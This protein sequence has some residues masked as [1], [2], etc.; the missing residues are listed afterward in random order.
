MHCPEC[1]SPIFTP[2]QTRGAEF[3]RE[4][5]GYFDATS[6]P[7]DV[8]SMLVPPTAREAC[9][10][11]TNALYRTSAVVL[12]LAIEAPTTIARSALISCYAKAEI[13][14]DRLLRRWRAGLCTSEDVC[15]YTANIVTRFLNL[16]SVSRDALPQTASYNLEME[17][18]KAWIAQAECDAGS[19]D[20]R[21]YLEEEADA[22][23]Q[24]L[25][26]RAQQLC[27]KVEEWEDIE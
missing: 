27:M 15:E 3:E 9:K 10:S 8:D 20:V 5:A 11:L 24:N 7:V 26:S 1:K 2:W 17:E 6:D 18:A 25:V 13:D 19:I 21:E 16:V 12:S 14:N 4:L 22:F 23:A